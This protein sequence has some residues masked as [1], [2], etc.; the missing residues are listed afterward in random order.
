MINELLTFL[1]YMKPELA[2]NIPIKVPLSL[3]KTMVGTSWKW[4]TSHV[5][6][7]SIILL[8][9]AGYSTPLELLNSVFTSDLKKWIK[10][11]CF[12][13]YHKRRSWGRRRVVLKTILLVCRSTLT[14]R[15]RLLLL[16]RPHQ[17]F[18]FKSRGSCHKSTWLRGWSPT[19]NDHVSIITSFQLPILLTK[20]KQ[21]NSTQHTANEY[22]YVNIGTAI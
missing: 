1:F 9:H 22:W 13:N 17:N 18:L 7:H 11:S 16:R 12:F 14:L 8:I 5:K 19:L 6:L 20:Y 4:F 3:L 10:G 21:Q 2:K 15:I